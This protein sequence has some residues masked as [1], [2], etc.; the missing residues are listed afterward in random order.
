MPYIEA[1]QYIIL[2]GKVQDGQAFDRLSYLAEK[3][4]DKY[5][6]RRVRDMKEVPEA[7]KRCMV[8]LIN[9][10]VNADPTEAATKPTVASFNNDGY[11][12]T[13]TNI[14]TADGLKSALYDIVTEYLSGV[15]DDN[16]TP[17]L[18]L[19]V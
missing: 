2:G 16:G 9:A 13:Y 8:E 11:S 17:L 10:M 18:W 15:E 1:D 3:L 19:G 7:V 12:E 6:Q 4:I 5:T 14:V